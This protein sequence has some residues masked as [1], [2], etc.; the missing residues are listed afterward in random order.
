MFVIFV[1]VLSIYDIVF[2][3][4]FDG[5]W[6]K[7]CMVSQ[8]HTSITLCDCRTELLHKLRPDESLNWIMTCSI[9]NRNVIHSTYSLFCLL[10]QH[11]TVTSVLDQLLAGWRRGKVGQS[12]CTS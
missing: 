8:A 6:K 3:F 11:I 2:L 1:T 9:Q 5:S 4:L 10:T 12:V 7:L